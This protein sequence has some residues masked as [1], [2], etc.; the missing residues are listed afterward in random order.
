MRNAQAECVAPMQSMMPHMSRLS[1]FITQVDLTAESAYDQ[2]YEAFTQQ[3]SMPILI[4]PIKAENLLFR[5]RQNHKA[6]DFESFGE[7]SYPPAESVTDFSRANKPGQQLFYASDKYETTLA[8][9]LPYWLQGAEVGET[10][11]VTTAAWML[12]SGIVVAMI[13]DFNNARLMEMLT[14]TSVWNSLLGEQPY[15]DYVNSFF[16]EQGVYN[17]GIYK[18]TS[19]FANALIHNTTA[20]GQNIQGILFTSAQDTSGWNVALIPKAADEHLRLEAVVK[21]RIR[22]NADVNGKP[23]YDNFQTPTVPLRLDNDNRWIIWR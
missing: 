22:R 17:R 14:G 3:F 10:F 19:A 20:V 1:Q 2:L 11:E 16:H 15:W 23:T 7:L 6:T 12:T 4:A 8:E 21:H 13:P 5:S 9:L 18:I